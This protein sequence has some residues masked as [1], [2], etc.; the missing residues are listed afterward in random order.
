MKDEISKKSYNRLLKDISLV[1]DTLRVIASRV[2][3]DHPHLQTRFLKWGR[4]E[5]ASALEIT[6][7]KADL[8][9]EKGGPSTIA[10]VR[11]LHS[12]EG[13]VTL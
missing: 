1:Y 5:T 2:A 4:F 10:S 11:I 6:R 7:I 8:P 12:G 9:P 13:Q 3:A